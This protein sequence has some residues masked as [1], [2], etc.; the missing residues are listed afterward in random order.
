MVGMATHALVPGHA[1]ALPAV[2]HVQLAAAVS[3]AQQSWHQ[4]RNPADRSAH[5]RSL[6]G[7]VVVDEKLVALVDVP[8][9][10]RRMMIGD[11]RDP[12]LPIAA[13][14]TPAAVIGEVVL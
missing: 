12:L 2:A 9:N 14:P 6:R 10:V 4:A 13:G 1:P 11:Q 8:G 5:A 3:A 7:G